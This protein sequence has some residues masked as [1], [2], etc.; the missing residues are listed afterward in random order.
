M[1]RE[2][3]TDIAKVIIQIKI[4]MVVRIKL[5]ISITH[6]MKR[7]KK[8]KMNKHSLYLKII[9]QIMKDN[10]NYRKYQE[11]ILTYLELYKAFTTNVYPYNKIIT[12]VIINLINCKNN[13][14][15]KF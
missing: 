9:L 2:W 5:V 11:I 4:L 7:S 1:K 14:F 12:H 13:T 3:A 10:F 8:R 6:V 15:F